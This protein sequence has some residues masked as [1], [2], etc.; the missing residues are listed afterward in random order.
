MHIKS[1]FWSISKFNYETKI[2]IEILKINRKYLKY[3][4]KPKNL[5]M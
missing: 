3:L 2:I 4:F 5:F 1:A